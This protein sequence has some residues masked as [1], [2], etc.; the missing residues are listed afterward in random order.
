MW[1]LHPDDE[2]SPRFGGWSDDFNTFEDACEAECRWHD[3]ECWIE[4]QDD[5]EARGTPNYRPEYL[6]NGWSDDMPF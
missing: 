6:T 3:E 1:N 4:A 5:L 2:P